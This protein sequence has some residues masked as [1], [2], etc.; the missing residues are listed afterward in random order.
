MRMYDKNF[1]LL[2]CLKD[3]AKKKSICIIIR[4]TKNDENEKR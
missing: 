3:E 2:I 1:K 4:K